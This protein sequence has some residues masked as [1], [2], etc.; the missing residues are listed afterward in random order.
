MATL[1]VGKQKGG[2]NPTRRGAHVAQFY[3]APSR[4]TNPQHCVIAH[5]TL[6]HGP[7]AEGFQA[8]TNG[9]GAPLLAHFLSVRAVS[10]DHD[11]AQMVGVSPHYPGLPRLVFVVNCSALSAVVRPTVEVI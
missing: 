7:A 10:T 5:L 4:V 2:S 11:A 9:R 3:P 8:R 1:A 6:G